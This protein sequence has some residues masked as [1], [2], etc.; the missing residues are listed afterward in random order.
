MIKVQPVNVRALQ[1]A[2]EALIGPQG[3]AVLERV[4]TTLDSYEAELRLE[5]DDGQ[6]EAARREGFL[7]GYDAA[8]EAVYGDQPVTGPTSPAICLPDETVEHQEEL[9]Q[10][11]SALESQRFHEGD[12]GDE[13]K[14]N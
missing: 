14:V 4:Y 2:V 5:I 9:A 1:K 12:S 6:F 7:E 13:N 10:A 11:V 8:M 3:A